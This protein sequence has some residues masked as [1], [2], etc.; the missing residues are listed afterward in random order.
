MNILL[1][2][3]DVLKITGLARSTLYLQ[4]RQGVIPPPVKLGE[5]CVAWPKHEIAAITAARIAEKTKEEIRQ[6][7]AQLQRQRTI[8]A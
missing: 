1:R 8:A 6:I 4:I 5:R 7:V 2:L 3:P